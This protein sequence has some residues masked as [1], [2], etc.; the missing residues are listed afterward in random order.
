MIG[1][2]TG[3][4]DLRGAV[5][6]I[7]VGVGAS[8]NVE[9][10]WEELREVEGLEIRRELATC[11]GWDGGYLEDKHWGGYDGGAVGRY[12]G[13]G[14]SNGG[15]CATTVVLWIG[16]ADGMCTHEGGWKRQVSK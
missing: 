13:C 12:R 15:L 6:G 16:D 10:D 5:D 7:G 3:A 9:A 11:D 1:S 14:V 8:A 4:G 2:R